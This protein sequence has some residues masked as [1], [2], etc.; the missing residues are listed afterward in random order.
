MQGYGSGPYSFFGPGITT[1]GSF[2]QSVAVYI[3]AGWGQAVPSYAQSFW[4]DMS[5]ANPDPNN[6]GAE[7]NFR[8]TANGSSVSASVD[9]QA[10]PITTIT[11]S[12]WYTFQ[13][14]YRHAS[15]PADPLLTDM[16][17]YDLANDAL[18]GT[19]TVE[20]TSPGGP[21]ASQ[22]VTGSGYVWFTVWPNGFAGDTLDVA[23]VETASILNPVPEPSTYLAGALL[24]LPFGVSTVRKLRKSRAA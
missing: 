20:A 18:M 15:N 6:Y 4:I 21:L 24:L 23:N 16:N 3:N 12:G 1:S 14:L 11:S 7:H 17:I 2:Y 22:D 13:M 9:G 19:T 8:I 10:S 5:P